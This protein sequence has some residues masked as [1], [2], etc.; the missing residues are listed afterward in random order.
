MTTLTTILIIAFI[1]LL[2][3][4][5]V[6]VLRIGVTYNEEDEEI[7][8]FYFTRTVLLHAALILIRCGSHRARII[9]SH[10]FYEAYNFVEDELET[11]SKD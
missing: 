9:P 1:V 8:T 6:Y 4:A 7:P 2:Q 5:P 10:V 11:A 3:F